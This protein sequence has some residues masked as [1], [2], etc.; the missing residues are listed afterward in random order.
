MRKKFALLLALLLILP[1]IRVQAAVTYTKTVTPNRLTIQWA[2]KRVADRTITSFRLDDVNYAQLRQM[3]EACGGDVISLSNGDYQVVSSTSTNPASYQTIE[4]PSRTTVEVQYNVTTIRDNSGQVSQ[5]TYGWVLLVGNSYNSSYNNYNLANLRDILNALELELVKV[6]DNPAAGTTVV[7]IASKTAGATGTVT[8]TVTPTSGLYDLSSK[9]ADKVMSEIDDYLSDVYSAIGSDGKLIIY[10][11]T[12]YETTFRYDRLTWLGKASE[13]GG[14]QQTF[15]TNSVIPVGH[16]VEFSYIGTSATPTPN[17]VRYDLS[18]KNAAK[19]A[20]EI[21]DYIS[22]VRTKSDSTGKTVIY[23]NTKNSTSFTYDDAIWVGR[24]GNPLAYF[25]SGAVIKQGEYIEFTY[26][27]SDSAKPSPY[28]PPVNIGYWKHQNNYIYEIPRFDTDVNNSATATRI[29]NEVR[30]FAEDYDDS[31]YNGSS[32]YVQ[33]K[34]YVL[35]T[36]QYITF[37]ITRHESDTYDTTR[38]TKVRS[39]VYDYINDEEYILD[40]ALDDDRLDEYEIEAKLE[41]AVAADTNTK[42]F[43]IYDVQA[44]AFFPRKSGTNV[45]FYEVEFKN[46][47]G[48]IRNGIAMRRHNGE[49][50]IYYEKSNE[51]GSELPIQK[52]YKELLM[53]GFGNKLFWETN[54]DFN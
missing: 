39:W 29:N 20:T 3:V 10:G 23:G 14:K 38:Y 17:S 32:S 35:K 50:D 1:A 51:G 13:V 49:Y 41:T 46:N 43:E 37:V 9:N 15:A 30:K 8:P 16:L 54:A 7:Q 18:D 5:P 11:K 28:V 4:F 40:D 24:S 25:D 36:D 2:D 12:K 21:T 48:D 52:R 34:S 31:S 47:N 26:I 22:T 27:G 19:V 44:T 42:D 6:D 45:Y 33:I 53:T